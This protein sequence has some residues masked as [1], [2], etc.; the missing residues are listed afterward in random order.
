MN[1]QLATCTLLGFLLV[2]EP[3]T[4]AKRDQFDDLLPPGA[5]ARLGTTRFRDRDTM[6]FAAISPDKKLLATSSGHSFIVWDAVTGSPI[7]IGEPPKPWIVQTAWPESGEWLFCLSFSPDGESLA[8]S[9]IE[10]KGQQQHVRIY[11]VRSGKL[12]QTISV[13][14]R[15]V[16]KLAYSRDGK[17]LFTILH[18]DNLSVW[19][20]KS[21]EPVKTLSDLPPRAL[22]LVLAPDGKTLALAVGEYSKSVVLQIHDLATGKLITR[23]NQKGTASSSLTFFPDGKAIAAIGPSG[24]QDGKNDG[25]MLELQVLAVGRDEVIQRSKPIRWNKEAIKKAVGGVRGICISPDGKLIAVGNGNGRAPDEACIIVFDAATLNET[26]RFYEPLG[27]YGWQHVYGLQFLDNDNLL[28]WGNHHSVTIWDVKTGQRKLPKDGPTTPPVALVFSPD[29]ETLI[30]VGPQGDSA[31]RL[32]K[33]ATNKVVEGGEADLVVSRAAV[34]RDGRFLV[35]ARFGATAAHTVDLTQRQSVAKWPLPADFFLAALSADGRLAAVTKSSNDAIQLIIYD[36][37]TGEKKHEIDLKEQF[38]SPF[39]HSPIVLFSADNHRIFVGGDSGIVVHDLALGRPVVTI[40]GEPP[41][42][43]AVTTDGKRLISLGTDLQIWEVSTGRQCRLIPWKVPHW[44]VYTKPMDLAANNR[45]L[46]VAKGLRDDGSASILDIYT[47]RELHTFKGHLGSVNQIAFS[48]NVRFL[49]TAGDD[50]TTVVWDL[51]AMA[52]QPDP[53]V[54]PLTE[55][56][57]S[58]NWTLLSGQDAAGALEALARL[59]N[60]PARSVP[61]TKKQLANA[62]PFADEMI[63]KLIANLDADEYNLR[64]EASKNLAKLGWTAEPA[65][66]KAYAKTSSAEVKARLERL[67][68]T[69]PKEKLDPTTVFAA[70]VTEL[71]ERVGTPEAQE[72]LTELAKGSPSAHLTQE[73]GDSVKRLEKKSANRR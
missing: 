3:P 73:A 47:G 24:E 22:D 2:G 36:T 54:K 26:A 65:M 55:D 13:G 11:D 71:L 69:L 63:E 45:W 23:F 39:V 60:D 29:D 56:Q 38:H 8:L 30:Q 64:E 51:A 48:H 19:D 25:G 70:R 20:V 72:L 7:Q 43:I 10:Y 5:V 42:K 34:S 37:K 40:D 17:W 52:H 57:L 59:I 46:A 21:G 6:I 18:D 61:F 33:F 12:R 32:W 15:H 50:T 31:Y 67:L 44:S 41:S 58:K 66:K 14:T 1:P 35:A 4:E 16:D 27:K 49:A 62:Q 53:S 28:T 9:V 68:T